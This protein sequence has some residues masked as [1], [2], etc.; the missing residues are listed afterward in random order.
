VETS[1]S[2]A[3]IYRFLAESLNYPVEEL[4]LALLSKKLL[5]EMR[6]AVG[7]QPNDLKAAFNGLER[8]SQDTS[9]DPKELLLDLEKDYTRMFLASRPRL[10]HLFESVYKEG[11]L[12]Q[13]STFEIARI[14]HQAGLT[15][16]EEFRLPPDHIALEFELMSYLAFQETEA[17]RAGNKENAE[18]ASLLQ[19]KVLNEHLRSFALT[20]AE[21]MAG[22]A[23]TE[24]YKVVAQIIQAVISHNI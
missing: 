7:D 16:R 6:D 11:K 17:K 4:S 5:A 24:F 21:K 14:Y 19:E 2:R 3:H 13:E 12:F 23:Q 10:V 1:A 15:P 20:V 22:N 18:Y 8:V 9:K